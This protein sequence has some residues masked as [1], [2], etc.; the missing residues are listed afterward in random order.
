MHGKKYWVPTPPHQL[1]FHPLRAWLGGTVQECIPVLK[2][3]YL[4]WEAMRAIAVYVL[5]IHCTMVRN[6]FFSKEREALL[7]RK[8]S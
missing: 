1:I 8:S 3:E 2:L 6:L 4:W 7:H 5:I